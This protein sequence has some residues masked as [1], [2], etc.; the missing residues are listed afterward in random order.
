MEENIVQQE[1]ATVWNVICARNYFQEGKLKSNTK[2][3]DLGKF[4]RQHRYK[5]SIIDKMLLKVCEDCN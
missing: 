1:A 2:K 4:G 3:P 5:M